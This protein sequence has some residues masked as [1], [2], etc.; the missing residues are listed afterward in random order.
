MT[1]LRG[2]PYTIY[3]LSKLDIVITKHAIPT[4]EGVYALNTDLDECNIGGVYNNTWIM[5]YFK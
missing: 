2:N 4:E 1:C 3:I 5:E